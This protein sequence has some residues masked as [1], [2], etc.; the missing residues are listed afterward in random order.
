M[1][2]F[3]FPRFDFFVSEDIVKEKEN[4]LAD[5]EAI[6]AE[7]GCDQH[8]P[9]DRGTEFYL[10]ECIFDEENVLH[11]F[12]RRE[13]F[14]EYVEEVTRLAGKEK[15]VI[16]MAHGEDCDGTWICYDGSRTMK[17]SAL[18]SRFSR[19]YP[20]IVLAICNPGNSQVRSSKSVL[21]Y[22]DS[23]I[24]LNPY[25]SQ[26]KKN[27]QFQLYSPIHGLLDRYTAGSALKDLKE[28]P[29]HS[30]HTRA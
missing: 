4:Q 5:D 24:N 20:A 26:L 30:N 8:E 12:T 17:P 14:L 21:M 25:T 7:L 9:E 13:E 22:P 29:P 16:I 18:V 3:E 10:R 15:Y 27:G 1:R 28:L 6:I 23:D 11:S 19:T 2:K